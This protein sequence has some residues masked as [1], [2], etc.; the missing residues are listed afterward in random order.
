VGIRTW[1]RPV[2]LTPPVLN[3]KEADM[4]IGEFADRAREIRLSKKAR[5]DDVFETLRR[6]LKT[7]AATVA[8]MNPAK[9][10][11]RRKPGRSVLRLP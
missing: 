1:A 10:Q 9:V 7:E 5:Y 4:Y 6:E 8:A 2:G 11:S 3:N